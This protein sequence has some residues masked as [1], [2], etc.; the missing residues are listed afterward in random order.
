MVLQASIT[1]W[2][3]GKKMTH[4]QHRRRP[5]EASPHTCVTTQAYT[6]EYSEMQTHAVYTCCLRTPL[7]TTECPT[8]SVCPLA[9]FAES[10]NSL[11]RFKRRK[12]QNQREHL[13][14]TKTKN[15]APWSIQVFGASWLSLVGLLQGET[16]WQQKG[17]IQ[18]VGVPR[19]AGTL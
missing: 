9:P 18:T 17:N 3:Q 10:K 19:K 14:K 5:Q 13:K 15:K 7:S 2:A 1:K 4:T 11:K 16:V 6:G 12:Q 8:L